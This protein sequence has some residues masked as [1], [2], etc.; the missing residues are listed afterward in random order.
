MLRFFW[1]SAHGL[2]SVFIVL[3]ILL[4]CWSALFRQR[5]WHGFEDNLLLERSISALKGKQTQFFVDAAHR[6]RNS[7]KQKTLKED[8][9]IINYAA[10]G[11][12]KYATLHYSNTSPIDLVF[13]T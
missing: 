2:L 3:G 12:S 10:L 4:S 13:K 11:R 5:A 8:F 9:N 6:S 1:Q 7:T